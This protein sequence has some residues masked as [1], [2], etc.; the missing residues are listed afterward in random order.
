[1]EFES[2]LVLLALRGAS[3]DDDALDTL[4]DI[5]PRWVRLER[6]G[7][8]VCLA[9]RVRH[10]DRPEEFRARVRGWAGERGWAVTVAPCAPSL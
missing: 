2:L 8:A 6:E 10:R 3:L 4:V 1:V 5:H 9:A 7:E